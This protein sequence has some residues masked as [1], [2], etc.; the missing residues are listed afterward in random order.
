M[1]DNGRLRQQAK[2]SLIL[3]LDNYKCYK[4]AMTHLGYGKGRMFVVQF[5]WKQTTEWNSSE[6]FCLLFYCYFCCYFICYSH[7]F[8]QGSYI[9]WSTKTIIN[10]LC[11]GNSSLV[12]LNS[13]S[14]LH[15][16]QQSRILSHFKRLITILVLSEKFHWKQKKLTFLQY[17]PKKQF[18]G[19]YLFRNCEH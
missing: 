5:D 2:Q 18:C 12:F 10:R 6:I 13:F 14:L 9:S 11:W 3:L 19:M 7:K 4:P 1:L 17:P 15:L 8:L 16:F